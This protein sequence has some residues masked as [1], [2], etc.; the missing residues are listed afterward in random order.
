MDVMDCF[1]AKSQALGCS[2]T[3]AH[4][5]QHEVG[6]PFIPHWFHQDEHEFSTLL[7]HIEAS[8]QWQTLLTQHSLLFEL[9]VSVPPES[10][11]VR[12][13]SHLIS[14]AAPVHLPSLHPPAQIK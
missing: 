3:Q 5:Q 10:T 4:F 7:A 11:L 13:E 12:F 6:L 14:L 2:Q 9:L 8:L 1:S